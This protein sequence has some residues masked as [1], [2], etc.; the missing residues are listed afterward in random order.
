[1][2]IAD[3]ARLLEDLC[4]EPR[5]TEWL[6]FKTSYFD[7]DEVGQYVSGLANSAILQ[8]EAHAYLVFGVEDET[9]KIVGTTVSLKDAKVGNEVFE[10]WLTRS[11]DPKLSA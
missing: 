8:G 10:N 7:A 6:E 1:M 4:A 2:P 3:P 5:E 9:H 11:L